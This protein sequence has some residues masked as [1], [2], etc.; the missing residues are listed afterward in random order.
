V[1]HPSVKDGKIRVAVVTGS[2]VFD[3]PE[4]IELF[5]SMSSIDF[6]MQDLENYAADMSDVRRHYDVTVFYN[7]HGK[8][9]DQRSGSV[10]ERLGETDQGILVLHHGILGFREWHIWSA[11]TGISDRAFTYHPGEFIRTEIA[12]P[13]HPIVRGLQPW[14]MQDE[15]YRM[16]SVDDEGSHVIL[17]TSHPKSLRSLAWTRKYRN[18][19]VFCYASGHGAA[20]YADPQFRAVV[21]RG[22]QWLAGQRAPSA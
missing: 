15:T 1:T 12:D 9:P 6:Y 20:T 3:V 22:I 21:E 13:S 16:N 18:A 8:A 10:I 14:V 4:F 7:M 19:P 11:V 2:H 17:T 5:R